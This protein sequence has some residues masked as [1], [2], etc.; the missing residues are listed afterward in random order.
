MGKQHRPYRAGRGS[1]TVMHRDSEPPIQEALSV[2]ADALGRAAAAIPHE[3]V[4]LRVAGRA[5]VP[6]ERLYCY[7]LYH[8]IRLALADGFR[9]SVGGEV[10]K[11]GHPVMHG[12]GITNTKPD[13]LIHRPGDMGGNLVIIEV[14]SVRVRH[15]RAIRKDLETLTAYRTFAEGGYH[16]A[17]Y[18][19]FGGS[20]H[21][22]EAA[23]DRC[24]RIAAGDG[25]VP[26]RLDLIDLLWHCD[27]GEPLVCLPWQEAVSGGARERAEML[28]L[29]ELERLRHER[30]A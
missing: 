28:S 11:R 18:L 5:R 14:K 20:I 4:S 3:Y 1:A 22:V 27:H 30:V 8:Q 23:R 15:K 24:E 25:P 17:Y 2:V 16:R 21:D 26:V 9:F 19:F 7:E 10:D 29:P 12:P 6:R 13:L